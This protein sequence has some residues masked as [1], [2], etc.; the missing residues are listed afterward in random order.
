M[1]EVNRQPFW[2][3]AH[4]PHTSSVLSPQSLPVVLLAVLLLTSPSPALQ[5]VAVTAVRSSLTFCPKPK[6]ESEEAGNMDNWGSFFP[7]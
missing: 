6:W 5:D 4:Q 3:L 1:L 2:W 7:S